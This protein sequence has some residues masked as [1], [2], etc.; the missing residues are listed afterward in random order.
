MIP[1]LNPVRVL[2]KRRVRSAPALRASVVACVLV[3]AAL[4]VQA[5]AQGLCS[6]NKSVS[7]YPC[8]PTVSCDLSNCANST[9]FTATGGLYVLTQGLPTDNWVWGGTWIPCGTGGNCVQVTGACLNGQGSQKYA[10][11][12]QDNGPCGVG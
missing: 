9:W 8:G 2:A 4:V 10:H 11:P 1:V 6:A 7:G 3:T 12:T 5:A